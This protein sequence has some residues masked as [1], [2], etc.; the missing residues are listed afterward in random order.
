MKTQRISNGVLLWLSLLILPATAADYRIVK[1]AGDAPIAVAEWG[2][3]NAPD[4]LLLHGAGFAKEYWMAQRTETADECAHYV[5]MDLRGHGASAKPWTED[6]IVDSKLW[7]TD[8]QAVITDLDMHNVLIVG[9]SYGGYVAMDYLRHQDSKNIAGVLLVGSAA[10]LVDRPQFSGDIPA[11][12][13]EAAT[14]RRSLNLDENRLGSSYIGALMSS[15]ELP[16]PIAS[17]WANQMASSPVYFRNMMSQRALDNTDLI[18]SLTLPLSFLLGERDLSV[19]TDSVEQLVTKRL[20]S[21]SV[22]IAAGAGHAV[23]HDSGREFY[24]T[25]GDMLKAGRSSDPD[26]ARCIDSL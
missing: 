6:Q 20:T 8:V 14:Q 21:A 9:W 1:G 12:F 3:K 7:A 11:G 15:Y 24:E 4:V 17:S 23:S 5:A 26:A 10:G 18:E 25:L 2:N 22:R 16:E 13:A 19:S